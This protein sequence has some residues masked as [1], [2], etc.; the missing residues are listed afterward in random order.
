MVE[1]SLSSLP[2]VAAVAYD[3]WSAGAPS[4]SRTDSSART[5]GHDKF[6]AAAHPRHGRVP[7][8]IEG[9]SMDEA[10]A[11]PDC[12]TTVEIKGL[13]PGRQVRCGFCHRLL[14]VPYLPRVAEP[15]WKRRRFEQPWWVR[16]A[17]SGLGLLGFLILVIAAVRFLDRQSHIALV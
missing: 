15:S 16:W 3:D 12:G 17:W 5:L 14:E 2:S 4:R 11:C 9:M 6:S 13:A 1:I 10:F 7:R 8:V